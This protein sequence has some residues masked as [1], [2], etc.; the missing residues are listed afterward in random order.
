MRMIV[1]QGHSW[2]FGGGG[3]CDPLGHLFDILAEAT[4]ATRATRPFTETNRKADGSSR[5]KSTSTPG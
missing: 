3:L 2:E 4:Y 5:R 1:R